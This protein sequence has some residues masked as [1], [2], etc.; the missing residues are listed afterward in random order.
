MSAGDDSFSIGRFRREHRTSLGD[1]P[2]YVMLRPGSHSPFLLLLLPF[3]QPLVCANW[4]LRSQFR[5][6]VR[7]RH[8]VV[9]SGKYGR[10]RR[11]GGEVE[12]WRREVERGGDR[13]SEVERGGAVERGTPRGTVVFDV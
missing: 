7:V 4:Y 2:G 6:G 3:L 1:I 12:R 10:V 8:R 5:L 11:E 13:R 9:H